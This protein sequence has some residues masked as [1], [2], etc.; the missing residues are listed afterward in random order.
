MLVPFVLPVLGWQ[1]GQIG[2]TREASCR[3]N[4]RQMKVVSAVLHDEAYR[5]AITDGDKAAI[6]TIVRAHYTSVYG[7]AAASSVDEVESIPW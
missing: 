7:D 4:E 6:E 2:V 5:K 3:M 1:A